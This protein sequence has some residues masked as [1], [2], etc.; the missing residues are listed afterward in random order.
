MSPILDAADDRI[1][2][3]KIGLGMA[4]RMAQRHKHLPLPMA[5]FT[6]VIL[7]DGIASAE[8]M[9]IAQ[10]LKDPFHRM[11]LFAV[12]RPIINQN[13]IDDARVRIQLGT[14]GWLATLVARRFRM[15]KHLS[16]RLAG[17]TKMTRRFTLTLPANMTGQPYT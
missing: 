17:Q 9:L 4:R 7:D 16:N 3:A 12:N 14:L 13:T 6:N 5:L 2:L 11:A 1:R 10:A 15:P 8:A